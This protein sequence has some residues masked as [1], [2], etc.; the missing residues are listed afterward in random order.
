MTKTGSNDALCV[1]WAISECFFFSFLI[2][3]ILTIKKGYYMSFKG[4][5]RVMGAGDDENGPKQ[6]FV[7]RLGH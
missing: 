5:E 3:L 1:V 7:R 6:R 2:F 4:S